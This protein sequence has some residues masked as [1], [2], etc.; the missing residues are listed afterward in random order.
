M[1]DKIL[2]SECCLATVMQD[3]NEKGKFYFKC[4]ACGK[5]NPVLKLFPDEVEKRRAE[6]AAKKADEPKKEQKKEASK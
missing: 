5:G 4:Q 3:D 1:Q 6:R 2:V